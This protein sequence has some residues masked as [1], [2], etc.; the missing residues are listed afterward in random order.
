MPQKCSCGNQTIYNIPG[1][2]PI[3]CKKCKT[4]KMIDVRNNKCPCG[5]RPSF[6]VPEEKAGLCCVK[7]K[8]DEMVDVVSKRCSCG[9]QPKFNLPGKK[10]ICCSKCKTDEMIDVKSKR[11]PCGKHPNFNVPGKKK[12]ICCQECK[13]DEMIDVKSKRC[14]CGKRPNFNLPG[15]TIGVCCSE[16]KTNDMV[17]VFAKPCPCG[18]IPSFN[19][20]G[21]TNGLCCS[22]CKTDEMIN[23]VNKRCSCG[24][25]P[26][27][28]VLG[29][30]PSCCVKCKTDEMINVVAKVCP[31]YEQSCPV[32]TRLTNGHDYCMSCD[33]NDAR[34]KL[35]KR[36][37]EAFFDYVKDKLDVHKREF[38]VTF[39]PNET[40]KKFARLDG[41]VF[42]DG[43]IV[44]LEVDE[45]GHEDYQ[46]DEHRMHL[47]TAELLQKY[48][49]HTVSWVRVNP[50]T[51]SKSQWS[52]KS[53]AIREKRFDD[54]IDVVNDILEKRD[55]RVV[56][57]GF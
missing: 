18:K 2:K 45:E 20:P 12:P 16:C 51:D 42:G 5:K 13:T 52:K 38:R 50:T 23:V 48:P 31:G 34:R 4:A 43:V 1:E 53:K 35:F 49:D 44:C 6:N 22:K 56:Y 28:N 7:C 3:C 21:E 37:E 30:K 40:F 9:K 15:K 55:T 33:P 10:P 14:P 8:T 32:R 54:V 41:I 57:I 26:I 19:I 11:C 24:N 29:K 25:Y 46:C 39:D 27:Y 17:N 36:Y 47:V